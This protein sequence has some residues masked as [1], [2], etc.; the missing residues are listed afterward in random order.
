MHLLT[1]FKTKMSE[2]LTEYNFRSKHH[3]LSEVLT[4]Y[5]STSMRSW[6]QSIFLLKQ[7]HLNDLDISANL[8]IF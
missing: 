3:G 5:N 1:S 2:L 4:N 7:E 6:F 8:G